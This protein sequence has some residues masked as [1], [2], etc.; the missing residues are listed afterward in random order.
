MPHSVVLKAQAVLAD[1]DNFPEIIV[2]S[3]TEIVQWN[4]AKRAAIKALWGQRNLWH[5]WL[6]VRGSS[7]AKNLLFRMRDATKAVSR[8]CSRE[9]MSQFHIGLGYIGSTQTKNALRF[10]LFESRLKLIESKDFALIYKYMT[11]A[12]AQRFDSSLKEVAFLS[13]C[14]HSA[15]AEILAWK[16]SRALD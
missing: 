10:S 5:K 3:A 14:G 8:E 9:E 7:P 12:N 11:C 4:Q 2:S 6:A 16:L 1:R 13:G 15:I